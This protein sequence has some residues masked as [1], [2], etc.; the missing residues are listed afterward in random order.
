[1]RLPLFCTLSLHDA[2]PIYHTAPTRPYRRKSESAYSVQ[3][4]YHSVCGPYDRWGKRSSGN[5][6]PRANWSPDA[7]LWEP[8]TC[9]GYHRALLRLLHRVSWA[10]SRYSG[11]SHPPARGFRCFP[12]TS[13]A[14]A[15]AWTA[16]TY[17]AYRTS[18]VRP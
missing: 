13:S 2:L 18:H 16:H 11:P 1:P 8:A 5:T 12:G 17:T 6:A 7:G 4:G 9:P 10:P 14:A 3:Y 15:S